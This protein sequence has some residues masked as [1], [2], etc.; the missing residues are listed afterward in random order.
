MM[1]V[2]NFVVNDVEYM[3]CDSTKGYVPMASGIEL[4]A[5]RRLGVGA[6]RVIVFTGTQ[7]EP[8]FRLYGADG[9]EQ[10]P[11]HEDYLVFACYLREEGIAANAAEMAKALGEQAFIAAA[12]LHPVSFEAHVTGA[13]CER[14][15][16]LDKKEQVLAG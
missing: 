9:E 15:R 2:K 11:Q 1:I 13:F 4:L 5:N 10:E 8:S 7:Q 3:I 16:A 14:I 12:E 6:D